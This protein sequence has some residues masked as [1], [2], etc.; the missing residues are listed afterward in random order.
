M[1]KLHIYYIG[2][3]D[4]SSEKYDR[5][6]GKY[7]NLKFTRINAIPLHPVSSKINYGLLIN[8]S[9]EQGKNG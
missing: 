2:H 9:T 4:E 1:K 8:E 7:I 6:M 3:I 5:V